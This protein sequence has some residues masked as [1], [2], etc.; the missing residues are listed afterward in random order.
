MERAMRPLE[1]VGLEV[2]YSLAAAAQG[3][4]YATEAARAVV[5]YALGPLGL[6]AVL[7][8]IDEGNV[9]STWSAIG[10]WAHTVGRRDQLTCAQV[11]RLTA[12]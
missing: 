11:L 12:A 6:P 5:Q 10:D 1:D 7:A 3:G 9:A 2:I 4:S 8:E